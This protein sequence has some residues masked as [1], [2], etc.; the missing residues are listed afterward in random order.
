MVV[1]GWIEMTQ[2]EMVDSW[3]HPIDEAVDMGFTLIL[4]QTGIMDIIVIILIGGVI[5]DVCRMSSRNQSHLH[6]MGK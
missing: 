1:T 3:I 4:V 5:G 2:S 6:L